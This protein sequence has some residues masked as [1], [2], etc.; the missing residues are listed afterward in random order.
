MAAELVEAGHVRLNRAKVTKPGHVVRP[1]DV[2]TIAVGGHVRVLRDL[3]PRFHGWRDREFERTYQQAVS[4]LCISP[5][6]RDAYRERYG[7]SGQVLYPSR[8]VDCP[9]YAVP[10]E[11]LRETRPALTGAYAGSIN[12][13]GYAHAIRQLAHSLAALGG[14][15]LLFGPL[16][17]EEIQSRGL[18]LPNVVP[19][20]LVSFREL[21]ER[22]RA[23]ADFLYVPMSFDAHDLPN[24]KLSF[25]SK[26]T[27]YT[28]AGL[29][30]LV[31]GP[32]YCSAVRWVRENPGLAEVA[33]SEDVGELRQALNRLA[34]PKRRLALGARVLAVGEK[35][36]SHE[37][38]LRVFYAA[39]QGLESVKSLKNQDAVA[40]SA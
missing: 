21:I 23:E 7:V 15:L 11:R 18:N 36:F 12:S 26:L 3:P 38:V 1:D 32:A 28:A 17:S 40:P 22:C 34:D 25:P 13:E 29:P 37:A 31:C 6:M 9:D 19:C 35:Y 2:L 24:M 30:L 39:L 14:Q 16:C 4:R 5:F 33:E 20:G 8:A 10:P 27:D